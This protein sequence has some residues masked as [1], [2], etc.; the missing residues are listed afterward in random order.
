MRNVGYS[1][2]HSRPVGAVIYG[3]IHNFGGKWN[4]SI[5]KTNPLKPTHGAAVVISNKI[6]WS[7]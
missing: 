4:K 7:R 2:Q 5:K 1:S 3:K 6:Y